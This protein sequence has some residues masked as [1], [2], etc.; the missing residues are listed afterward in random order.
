M[1]GGGGGPVGSGVV[2]SEVNAEMA[3]LLAEG[4]FRVPIWTLADGLRAPT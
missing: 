2:L 4:G 3:T 1:G